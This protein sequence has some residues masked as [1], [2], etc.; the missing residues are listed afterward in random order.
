MVDAAVA[1]FGRIDILVNN[2]AILR[3]VPIDELNEAQWDRVMAVNLKG[4]FL[5]AQAVLK[6]MVRQRSGVIVNI[7]SLA[8]QIGG[9]VAPADYAASKA[10]VI[11]LT[12]SLA[13]S[14]APFGV[15]VNCVSPAMI[16]TSMSRMYSP[17]QR[18]KLLAGVLLGR[19]GRAEEVA[20][21]VVFLAS[22]RASFITGE[23]VQVNGG[24]HV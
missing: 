6:V 2:A 4:P 3:A 15:R 16:E 13:K 5:C 20:D 21:V 10:G 24:L 7:A 12:K 23:T 14:A 9:V 11:C 22:Q 1:E 8:G 18:K 19:A 17:E